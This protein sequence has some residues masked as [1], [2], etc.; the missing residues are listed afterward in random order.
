MNWE[1]TY[2]REALE[3]VGKPIS[4]RQM[5]KIAAWA[6]SMAMIAEQFTDAEEVD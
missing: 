6:A 5:K 4:R 1:T 2:L 3:I